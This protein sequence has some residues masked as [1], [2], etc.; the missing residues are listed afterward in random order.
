MSNELRVVWNGLA[1]AH[2]ARWIGLCAI[3]PFLLALSCPH[4]V[5]DPSPSS[6][7]PLPGAVDFVSVRAVN[8][9][10]SPV[11]VTVRFVVNE[12]EVRGVQRP[13]DPAGEPNDEAVI[14]PSL[15]DRVDVSF[16]YVGLSA[17]PVPQVFVAGDG[18]AGRDVIEVVAPGVS[19]CDGNGVDDAEDLAACQGDPACEDCNGNGRPDGCDL[20]D[21][22]SSDCN[23]NGRPDECEPDGDGDGVVDDCDNCPEAPNPSQLDGDGDGV[24]DECEQ[25]APAPSGPG[26]LDCNVNG[27]SDASDIAN[28]QG[29]PT[30]GDCN[31]NSVPD[32]CEPDDDLDT[33]INAC[34]VCPNDALDVC[35]PVLNLTQ[36]TQHNT[37]ADGIANA[38][39]GDELLAEA[40]RFV[41]EP[42]VDFDGKGIALR[43]RAATS[44][45]VGGAMTLADGATLAAAVGEDVTLGGTLLVEAGDDADITS[46][47]FAVAATGGATVEAGAALDVTA[48][49]GATLD[50]PTQV[51]ALAVLSFSAAVEN[52][53]TLTLNDGMVTAATLDNTGTITGSGT[54]AAATTTNDNQVTITDDTEIQGDLVNNGTTTVQSGVLTVS[55]TI[56]DDGM[57]VSG[58]GGVAGDGLRVVGNYAAAAGA[59]LLMPGGVWTVTAEGDFDPAIDDNTRYDMA[60][61]T[62]AMTGPDGGAQTLEAMSTGVPPASVHELP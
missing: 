25:A 51:D 50:G 24:G 55:G 42:I 58:G 8:A 47:A 32:G 4:L 20:A 59:S 44:Q 29:D 60:T 34:D 53:D 28:C 31:G 23:A 38:V 21:G 48:A 14:G 1:Q 6:A 39:G 16:E 12:I 49:A 57:T 35:A 62:L 11:V 19:D 37:I 10:A 41:S 61:A 26:F 36:L 7:R 13:L 46:D 56:A 22:T 2:R 15:A 54:I 5:E 9:S 45:P 40:A 43:S 27:I 33:V 18:F 17:R 3:T 52:S 30:C